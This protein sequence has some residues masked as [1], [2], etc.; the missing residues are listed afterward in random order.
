MNNRS[1]DEEGSV[2]DSLSESNNTL[3]NDITTSS[4]I[5]PSILAG[6][7]NA[8]SAINEN[9]TS[10]FSSAKNDCLQFR[11]QQPQQQQQ[12]QQLQQH[13]QPQQSTEN[14]D[15]RNNDNSNPL[16]WRENLNLDKS[17][18]ILIGFSKGCVVLN[19]VSELLMDS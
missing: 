3:D 8:S 18:L 11:V 10:L 19:Q 1:L 4:V 14:S 7:E 5:C 15:N 17:K 13:H 9:S 12:Q 2:I 16:W 6:H